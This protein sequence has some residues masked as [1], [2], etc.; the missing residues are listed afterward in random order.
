MM[1]KRDNGTKAMLHHVRGFHRAL[2]ETHEASFV[3]GP[4]TKKRKTAGMMAELNKFWAEK[5][6]KKNAVDNDK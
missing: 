4:V 6:C 2:L 1:W 3:T 5:G